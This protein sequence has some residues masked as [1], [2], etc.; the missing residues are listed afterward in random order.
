[1]VNFLSEAQVRVDGQKV[2]SWNEVVT[3]RWT[4]VLSAD[5]M[6]PL[7]T[8]ELTMRSD[9]PAAG[10]G[11]A[12]LVSNPK[13]IQ[14][15]AGRKSSLENYS[16]APS[17]ARSFST[18]YPRLA[19]LLRNSC[20]PLKRTRFIP[21]CLPRHLRAGLSC[22]AAPRLEHR[23]SHRHSFPSS[24]VTASCAVGCILAPLRG[25]MPV[26]HTR[27]RAD[28]AC[29]ATCSPP[30]TSRPARGSIPEHLPAAHPAIPRFCPE[31]VH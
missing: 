22:T 6:R 27:F 10:G 11:N 21:L 20:R 13:V 26:F 9:D 1:M 2:S 24:F 12:Q 7:R 23:L 28:Q 18:S 19:S 25:C 8:I 31:C 15:R 3:S 16:F 5:R 14:K 4:S 17:G 29:G 30:R